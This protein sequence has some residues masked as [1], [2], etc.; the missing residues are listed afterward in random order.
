MPN[1]LSEC[2]IPLVLKKI[3]KDRMT[4]CLTVKVDGGDRQLFFEKGVLRFARTNDPDLRLGAV[5]VST[6][7]IS[8]VELGLFDP[9]L[10]VR[11]SEKV[12][13]VLT[14]LG[15]ISTPILH[16]ALITQMV[17]ITA[18]LFPRKQGEWDFDPLQPDSS[19]SGY[20]DLKV[21]IPIL[22]QE[23]VKA[24]SDFSFYKQTF[25]S[26]Y[27]KPSAQFNAESSKLSLVQCKFISKVGRF[28][29]TP[30]SEMPVRMNMN[31]ELYWRAILLFYLL[32]R[33]EFVDPSDK[34]VEYDLEETAIIKLSEV[35]KQIKAVSQLP[36]LSYPG[37]TQFEQADNLNELVVVEEK[38]V[39]PPVAENLPQDPEL[40]FLLAEQAFAQR[41]FFKALT[42][43]E[44]ALQKG[45]ARP[46]YYQLL[47]R[48]QMQFPNLRRDAE[49]SFLKQ[50]GMEPWNA[51]PYYY[52]GELYQLEGL[53]QRAE[54]QFQ[55]ALELNLE[56]TKAGIRMNQ[57]NPTLFRSTASQKKGK[58]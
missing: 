30:N 37:K 50:A 51:D 8:S 7:S 57:L 20:D 45:P 29:P 32:G 36:D 53:Y 38:V 18:D 43:M 24:I 21:D 12:G 15:L 5:L 28:Y 55:K 14:D 26:I 41:T 10:Q 27:P 46:K 11:S 52:L 3:G 48:T 4:G 39:T 1:A 17:R 35:E 22:M 2:T 47:G 42:L 25:A 13:A 16:Q 34:E 31:E 33:I 58:K 19:E 9:V 40:I 44:T 23:G 6:G 49:E 54:K 56:H